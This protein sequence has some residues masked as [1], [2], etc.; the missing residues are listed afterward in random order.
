MSFASVLSARLYDTRYDTI[1]KQI[2]SAKTP[3]ECFQAET[4]NASLR[5][6]LNFICTPPAATR[7]TWEIFPQIRLKNSE[8]AGMRID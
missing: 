3:T 7:V 1:R 4:E 2:A 8:V 6:M 5:A